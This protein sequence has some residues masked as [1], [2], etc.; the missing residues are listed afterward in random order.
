MRKIPFKIYTLYTILYYFSV[1]IL[2]DINALRFVKS[3]FTEVNATEYIQ[4]LPDTSYD[5][6][7]GFDI[8]ML[9]TK[10]HGSA[11]KQSD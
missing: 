2:C 4:P 10:K 7:N 11:R 1:I 9:Y 8:M 5:D 6:D 3:C